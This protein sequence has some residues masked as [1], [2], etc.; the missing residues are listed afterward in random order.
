[1][2]PRVKYEAC[3]EFAANNINTTNC[4]AT[5]PHQSTSPLPATALAIPPRG[6][7]TQQHN[8]G[9][10]FHSKGH[11]SVLKYFQGAPNSSTFL[12]TL[13]T[14]IFL[15]SDHRHKISKVEASLISFFFF[16]SLLLTALESAF[17]HFQG[18]K[19]IL[20]ILKGTAEFLHSVRQNSYLLQRTP[21]N[22]IFSAQISF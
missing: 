17:T 19:E 22:P 21:Q 7:G 10:T 13:A 3:D 4:D 1:M 18:L 16:K 11:D 5:R 15:C 6:R 12:G 14:L 9:F 8:A 2:V 20:Y